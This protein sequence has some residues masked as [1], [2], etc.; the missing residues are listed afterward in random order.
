MSLDPSE[1]KLANEISNKQIA[2]RY[3]RF[4]FKI[5][6]V[7]PG[8]QQ[9]VPVKLQIVKTDLSDHY[10]VFGEFSL[11]KASE[12]SGQTPKEKT[13]DWSQL[14]IPPGLHLDTQQRK[15]KNDAIQKLRDMFS[16]WKDLSANEYRLE[17]VGSTPL[18][19]DTMRSDID[20]L[21]A[22]T[23]PT[24]S[25]FAQAL[26]FV[27][28]N[29]AKHSKVVHSAKL[30]I[31]KFHLD[32]FLF[33]LQYASVPESVFGAWDRLKITDLKDVD[34]PSLVALNSYR[35][36]LFFKRRIPTHKKA[37]HAF[38]TVYILLKGWLE[39]NGI[40]GAGVGY[41]NGI[42]LLILLVKILDEEYQDASSIQVSPFLGKFFTKF[43]DYN[44]Q[45]PVLFPGINSGF[46]SNSKHPMIIP[47]VVEP[48]F[49]T[50]VSS[51]KGSLH[52]FKS[53]LHTASVE[54]FFKPGRLLSMYKSYLVLFVHSPTITTLLE[55]AS[56]C[57][58]RLTGLVQNFDKKCPWMA[59]IPIPVTFKSLEASLSEN[60]TACLVI[61]FQRKS[62]A[63]SVLSTEQKKSLFHDVVLN[64]IDSTLPHL[65]TH[66]TI[67]HDVF[68][69]HNLNDGHFMKLEKLDPNQNVE[70]EEESAM[71]SPVES[72][73]LEQAAKSSPG[74]LRSSEDTYNR[75]RWD[76]RFDT[77]E[78][79]IGYL[80]RFVG[81]REMAFDKF[82]HDSTSEN[83]IPFHR[84]Y[85]FKRGSETMWD[86]NQRIDKIFNSP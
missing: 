24:E 3:D 12:F 71:A 40:Y 35:H 18:E 9:L 57:M 76:S 56:A 51:S 4:F 33:D 53:A 73:P 63:K 30:S 58:S 28:K 36:V 47:T 42:S 38:V 67:S 62:T 70:T 11:I 46:K 1:N 6:P 7:K 54:N 79:V 69:N 8:S 80:D 22:G 34:G 43:K 32:D 65:T 31:M 55:N 50:C 23:L 37:N 74:K 45:E 72:K 85:Y 66:A 83:F 82:K 15:Q 75:I 44:W 5:S 21:V 26:A 49:N 84:V 27:R 48:F 68:E 39:R 29:G 14:E 2:A 61:G 25:F 20:I 86:R 77:S 41:L 16:R 78:F 64:W 13:V 59:A 10:A 81:M 60:M 19:L 17:V 52:A